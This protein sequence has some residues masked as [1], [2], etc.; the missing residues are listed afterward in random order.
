MTDG[1]E[2][3]AEAEARIEVEV[4]ALLVYLEVLLVTYAEE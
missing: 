4:E 2:A 3:E 1:A